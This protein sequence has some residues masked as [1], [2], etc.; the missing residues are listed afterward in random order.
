MT[1]M[2]MTALRAMGVMLAVGAVMSGMVGLDARAV[3]PRAPV[4]PE[5]MMS[6]IGTTAVDG[7]RIRV[8]LSDATMADYE[9]PQATLGA[10]GP[11]VIWDEASQRALATLPAGAVAMVRVNAQGFLIRR[12]GGAPPLG[13]VAGPLRFRPVN[14]QSLMLLPSSP[15]RGQTPRYRGELEVTRGLSARNK[16]SVVNIL[17]IQDYLKAVVP[18][19]LPARFGLEAI[20]AQA[21]AARNYALRP[22]EKFWPQFDICDSQYCQV[23]FG[24]QTEHPDTSRALEETRG[25]VALYAGEPILALY[26]SSH[27]GVS[28]QYENAFS[29]AHTDRF[30]GTPLPFLT[31]VADA[32]AQ[33]AR[34]GDLRVE[35]NARA[36]WT[37]RGLSSFDAAS[38][39]NRWERVFTADQV[40]STLRRTLP[41]LMREANTRA[42][43]TPPDPQAHAVAGDLRDIRVTRR[44]A[45]GKAMALTIDTGA[46]EWAVRKEFVIRKALAVGGRMLPSANIVFTPQRDAAGRLQSLRIQGGGFGHGVGMSQYGASGMSAQGRSFVEILQHYY[47]GTALGTI[48]LVLGPGAASAPLR[49]AFYAKKPAGVLYYQASDAGAPPRVMLNG[50]SL[51]L[52]GVASGPQGGKPLGAGDLRAPGLN[53]LVVSPPAEASARQR[54]RVWIELYPARRD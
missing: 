19:E 42:F 25:L 10:T 34:Y 46:G 53:T 26:S 18:N 36:F 51:S 50:R 30:P 16:L 12:S 27:G 38:S 13:P 33:V 1:A 4:P 49:L 15:R 6:A 32:P 41:A 21:V 54:I 28:E 9:Y 22:R 39:Y 7:D 48:P 8:G 20:R 45:S 47:H 17:P 5:P 14:P 37:A 3:A 31:R 23:Y 2:G 11:C 52:A 43:V 35:A 24:A 40:M 44:G 29:D